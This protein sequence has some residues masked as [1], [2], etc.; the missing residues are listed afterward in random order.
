MISVEE[1]KAL[2]IKNI[3]ELPPVAIPLSEAAGHV[4]AADIF[5]I[6]DIPAFRQSSMDGYAMMYID[7]D[8]T[9]QVKGEMYAGAPEP[10]IIQA[11][12]ACRIFTGGPLPEGADTVVMQEK[13]SVSDGRLIIVSDGLE[14]GDNVREKGAEIQSGEL[15]MQKGSYLTPAAVGFLAGIGIS[16]VSVYPGPKVAVILTGKELQQPGHP[17]AFGQVYESNSY[18]LGA[19]LKIAGVKAITY[20]YVDDDLKELKDTLAKAITDTDMILLTGGVS[21][22]DYDF[23]VKAADLCGAT[24]IFHKVK[25]KPGKPLY[26]GKMENKVIFGLPGNPS[27]VLSCFYNYV[28]LAIAGLSQQPDKVKFL[29]ATLTHAIKKPAG[30]TQFLKG[31][32]TDGLTASLGAQESFQLSSFAHANCLIRLAESQDSFAKGDAVSV[33]LLP[34]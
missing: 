16:E 12:E 22:G 9:F 30:L 1:A 14:L 32:Y 6:C 33:L 7:K 23:V 28:S 29:T 31:T 3:T 24:Q 19:A 17:L 27:S 34:E 18:S 20:Y 11:G 8:M 2:V 5:A 26:F 13:V 21:V 4:L 25:Q 15:A 10:L